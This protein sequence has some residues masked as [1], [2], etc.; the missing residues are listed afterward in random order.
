MSEINETVQETAVE[1]EEDSTAVFTVEEQD[2]GTRLDKY[3]CKVLDLSRK[4]VA[5]LLDE[6]CITVNGEILKASGKVQKGDEVA[7][8]LPEPENT[9]VLPEEMD[10]DIVY[11]D[12][13]IIVINKPKGMVVH[14]APGHL[15]H[16]LVN[17]LLAHCKDLSGINGVMRPGIV[18]RID[19]DTSGL[20]VVAKNDAAHESLSDQL[21]RKECRREYDAL[22]HGTF[23]HTIGT[24]DAPIGRDEKDRQ[25]MAVTAK[26]SKPAVTH[27]EVLKNYKD[28]AHLKVRLETGRTHQIRV[29]MSYIDHPIVGDPKYGRRKTLQT[30]GQLLHASALELTHPRTGEHMLFEAPLDPIF[31]NVLDELE[32]GTL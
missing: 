32:A 8:D 26:N 27:F 23:S 4:R 5:D 19:K 15:S 21:S 28:Y 16:T 14:P 24:I 18:H 11:E 20:L 3:V 29:H 10:L 1:P 22:V 7:V 6:G 30:Q 12:A 17:G 31:Q 25:K 13:D 2:A 9:D